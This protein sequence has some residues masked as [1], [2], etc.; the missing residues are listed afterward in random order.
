ML[1]SWDYLALAKAYGAR[2]YRA[3]TV[4]ELRE[5]LSE[6][7]GLADAPALVEVVIPQKDLAPQLARLAETPVTVRKYRR[8]KPP[9]R[10]RTG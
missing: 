3:R 8:D 10:G 9:R 2:G 5:V 1:P 6:V 7:K 4:E